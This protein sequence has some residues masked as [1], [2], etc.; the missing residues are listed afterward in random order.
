MSRERS[1]FYLIPDTQE[2]SVNI[3]HHAA[4]NTAP[5]RKYMSEIM[6]TD[7]SISFV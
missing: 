4:H 1:P 2:S 6:V 3:I 7:D 5:Q